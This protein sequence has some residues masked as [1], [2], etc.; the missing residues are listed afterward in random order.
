MDNPDGPRVP[1]F[2]LFLRLVEDERYRGLVFGDISAMT[3]FT[4]CGRSLR[5]VLERP[6]LHRALVYGSDYPVPAI[7]ILVQT[8]KLVSRGY[9][10]DAQATALDEIYAANPL[11]FDFV[12][13][14]TLRAPGSDK[15]FSAEIF[16][17]K[18]F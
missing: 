10:T 5:T 14:R 1:N 2:D 12:L 9:I 18:I 13:K 6:E 16:T 11:L 17:R 4:R 3:L 8:G 15:G 7:D